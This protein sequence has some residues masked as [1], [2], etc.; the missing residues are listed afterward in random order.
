MSRVKIVCFRT[1]RVSIVVGMGILLTWPV[2]LSADESQ[3]L[4]TFGANESPP[5]WSKNLPYGGL[6]GELLH[7]MSEE[8]NLRSVVEFKPIK[9]LIEDDRKNVTGNPMFFLA[10]HDFGSTIPIALYY[11][12]LFS[13]RPHKKGTPPRSRN[14]RI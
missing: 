3:A 2:S 13:Y 6:C 8:I 7:A 14:W 12:A 10:N 1:I 4:V 9:R 5:Y 11:S